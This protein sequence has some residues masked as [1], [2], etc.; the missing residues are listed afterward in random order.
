MRILHKT[1]A[2]RE[3]KL[4]EQLEKQLYGE[5]S[6][7][8]GDINFVNTNDTDTA[9]TVIHETLHGIWS[10]FDLEHEDIEEHVIKT[11]ATG[12]V[13]VMYDNP[14]FFPSLQRMIDNAKRLQ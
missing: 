10:A 3:R 4:N 12:I 6:F 5:I 13:T 14:K 9:D 1:Y 11:L 8:R 7:T 2:L